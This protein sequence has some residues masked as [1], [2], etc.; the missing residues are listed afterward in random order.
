MITTIVLVN[1]YTPSR[2]YH[3]VLM[4]RTLKIYSLSSFEVDNAGLLMAVAKL[5]I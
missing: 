3:L 2:N 5:Y 1:T 4:L